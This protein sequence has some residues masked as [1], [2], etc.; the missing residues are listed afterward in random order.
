VPRKKKTEDEE[1]EDLIEELDDEE[2]EEDEELE[3]EEDEEL[4]DEED[5]EDEEEDDE[6][7]EEDEDE[8]EE[9]PDEAPR[10]RSRSRTKKKTAP[11]KQKVERTGI[12][13]AELADAAGVDSRTLRMYLRSKGIEKREGRYEW[14]SL[15]DPEAKSILRGLRDKEHKVVQK[16]RLD[17]LKQ[18]KATKTAAK[19]PTA[20][21][22]ASRS[23]TAAKTTTRRARA[24]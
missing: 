15:N 3:E 16:E 17:N 24:R 21:K 12:G 4:E 1:I 14:K 23:K 20:K 9:D 6:E 19:K 10:A 2:V 5:E 8:D 7:E 18:K 13:T 22:T 11:A